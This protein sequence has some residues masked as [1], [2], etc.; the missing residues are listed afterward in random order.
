MKYIKAF[1]SFKINEND[2]SVADIKKQVGE[3]V[4][5]K[6]DKLSDDEKEKVKKELS[7]LANK[8][9]LSLEDMTD[10]NKVGEALAKQAAE[11]DELAEVSESLNEGLKDW[12]G[13]VKQTFFKWLTR[14]GVMGMIGGITSAA[15]GAHALETATNLADFVPNSVVEPNTAIIM[16]GIAVVISLTATLIG[17]NNVETDRAGNFK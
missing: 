2:S 5:S 14:L 4:T 1:E 15:I 16:G 12:W 8:L 7:D 17:L 9:G 11:A 10:T 3:T 13:R 6:L